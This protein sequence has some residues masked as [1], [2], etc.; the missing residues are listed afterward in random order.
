MTR[1]ATDPHWIWKAFAIMGPLFTLIGHIWY[2]WG[3]EIISRIVGWI[4]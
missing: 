2:A 3:F 1:L 4:L